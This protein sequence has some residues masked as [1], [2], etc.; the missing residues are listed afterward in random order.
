MGLDAGEYPFYVMD[1]LDGIALS[2]YIRQ[3]QRLAFQ[4]SLDVF[5]QIASGLGYAHSKG[6]VHRDVK[7]SNIV[8]LAQSNGGQLVKIVDFGIA[9]VTSSAGLHSQAQTASGEVLGSPLYMSPE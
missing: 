2:D 3:K 5:T 4:E 7:P 6:I 8:L 1:L 9:K